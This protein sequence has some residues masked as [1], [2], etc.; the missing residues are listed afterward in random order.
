MLKK[1][2]ELEKQALAELKKA[3]TLDKLKELDIKYLGR[4]SE[5]TGL[6]KQ[7]KDLSPEEKRSTGQATNRLR[8]TLEEAF[9]NHQQ[10]LQNAK[11]EKELNQEFFDTTVPGKIRSVGHVHPLSQVQEEVERIF[12]QMGFAIMDGPE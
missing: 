8:Q 10:K 11:L 6:L 2:E 9:A 4:K 3:D 1:L 12:N 7:L 5:L